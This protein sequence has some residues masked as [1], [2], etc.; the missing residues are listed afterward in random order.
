[1][2]GESVKAICEDTAIPQSTMYYWLKAYNAKSSR[3]ESTTLSEE[4][5]AVKRRLKKY[6]D[7]LEIMREVDCSCSAPAKQK[8][9][10]LEKVYGKYSVHALC[11]AL[12][13]PRG[14]FYNHMLRNKRDDTSYSK[15]RESLMME[16]RNIYDES[17][18]IFGAGKIRAVLVDRGHKISEK[19][20]S[21]LMRNLGISSIR[22]SSRKDSVALSWP[23]RKANILLRNFDAKKPNI[24]WATDV[25]C[26]KF[27]DRYYYICV[28]MDLFSR[29]IVSMNIGRQNSTRL[30]SRVFGEAYSDRGTSPSIIHSDQGTPYTSYTMRVLCN[31]HNI[32]HSFSNPGTPHDN[33]VVESFFSTLKKEELYRG[34][35]KSEADLI[36]SLKKYVHFYNNIRPHRYLSYKTP[37]QA[38]ET[39]Y[40][41]KSKNNR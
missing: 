38:E 17:N 20:V 4:L 14:T 32:S 41:G 2:N 19:L 21:E 26:Y 15:R 10:A 13:V 27:K 37:A 11:D 16:I 1:M 7:M 33:A 35:Y 5:Y 9:V 3:S 34:R 12:N 28:F 36:G 24:V 29:R 8:L 6:E 39:V 18:Q 23:E 22:N 40:Y 25:T 31:K 30:V